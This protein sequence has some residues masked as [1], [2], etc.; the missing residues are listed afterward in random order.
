LELIPNAATLRITPPERRNRW[1]HREPKTDPSLFIV[2][3]LRFSDEKDERF[4]GRI[5]EH[6]LKLADLAAVFNPR[7]AEHVSN[8]LKQQSIESY[9]MP[10][11]EMRHG[12]L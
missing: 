11:P 8:M 10:A 4:E 7:E 12:S 6:V 2:E 1:M 3:S 5:L 9:A